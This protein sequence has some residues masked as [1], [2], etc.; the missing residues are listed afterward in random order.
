MN[1][2]IYV[3]SKFTEEFLLLGAAG[4]FALLS[5]YCYHWVIQKRRMGIARNQIP[6]AVV[7][8]Y[9]SQLINEAESVRK[10][11]FGM[12]DGGTI[13]APN[14]GSIGNF[15]VSAE[16][17]AGNAAAPAGAAINPD[18][19]ARINSLENQLRDKESLVVNINVEK[20]KLLQKENLD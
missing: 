8:A 15:N 6:S 14:F 3:Y 9:L 7:K 16:N 13:P 1:S 10:Q 18:L 2:L 11:L 19:M 12:T 5:I 17:S 4:F 20:N